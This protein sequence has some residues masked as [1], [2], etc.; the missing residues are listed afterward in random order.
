MNTLA[1]TMKVQADEINTLHSRACGLAAEAVDAARQA[2]KLLM[3]VRSELPHG[4][5]TV[6]LR[7]NC[8]VSPRQAQRYMRAASGKPMP[9]R[10]IAKSDTVSDLPERESSFVPAPGC[11]TYTA[12]NNTVFMV[13]QST[14]PAHYFVSAASLVGTDDGEFNCTTRPIRGDFAELALMQMGLVNPAGCG[15]RIIRIKPVS[16]ALGVNHG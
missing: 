12:V 3:E 11:L 1:V 7:Q 6:W 15:W 2:G 16:A 8:N 9:I 14:S 5:F 13:E 10:A 4:A